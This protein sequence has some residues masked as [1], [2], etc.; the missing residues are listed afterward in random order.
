[1]RCDKECLRVGACVGLGSGY[2]M[3]A[4]A[5]WT[6]LELF[7]G[8]YIVLSFFVKAGGASISS[9]SLLKSGR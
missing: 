3:L 4:I 7:T 8:I 2:V 9:L 6:L 5:T 1:M